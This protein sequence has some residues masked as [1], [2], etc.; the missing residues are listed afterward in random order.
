MKIDNKQEF[1][2][3]K[4]NYL[5][6]L[7]AD[8]N[9]CLV[10]TERKEVSEIME[11][12]IDA[13]NS[14]I[15]NNYYLHYFAYEA[16]IEFFTNKT[17]TKLRLLLKSFEETDEG[18]LYDNITIMYSF[19][20]KVFQIHKIFK[21][22]D[23]L[24]KVFNNGEFPLIRDLDDAYGK[25]LEGDYRHYTII[26]TIINC[27]K[28]YC[29]INEKTDCFWN[30]IHL[31]LNDKISLLD[32]LLFHCIIINDSFDDQTHFNYPELRKYVIYRLNNC[33]I[34]KKELK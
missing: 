12:I 25:Y 24:K 6:R 2:K 14:F 33:D 17:D 3:Y 16:L 20:Y 32:D 7:L 4:M 13:G 28:V 30:Y 8:N 26:H 31:L 10:G 27:I 34:D 15:L 19:A 22:R 1:I 23:D 29:V 9:Y 21:P 11:R 5:G 18:K